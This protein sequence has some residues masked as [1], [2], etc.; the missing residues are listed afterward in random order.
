MLKNTSANYAIT[1]ACYNGLAYT[2]LCLESLRAS[3]VDMTR[4]IVVDNASTDGT[5]EFLREFPEIQVILNS[6]NMGCGVAWNQGALFFQSEW[7]V[8]MNNDVV[9]PSSFIT[10]LMEAAQGRKLMA[11][12]PAMIEGPL[13]YD[14]QSNAKTWS[15]EMHS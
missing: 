10:P 8:I 1:F 4:V 14:F 12:S 6:E 15:T 7:T 5:A 11:L 3:D 2:K 13:G 9:V